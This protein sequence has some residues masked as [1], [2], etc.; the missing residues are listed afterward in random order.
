MLRTSMGPVSGTAGRT[1]RSE[2]FAGPTVRSGALA[3]GC[4]G[5]AL[6]THQARY[7]Q[8]QGQRRGPRAR[9]SGAQE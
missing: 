8:Q 6:P 7:E 4:R 2:P 5:R 9:E 3:A 1:A